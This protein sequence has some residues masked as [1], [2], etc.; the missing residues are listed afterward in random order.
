MKKF[1]TAKLSRNI[2]D[3]THAASQAP[4]AITQHNK[5]RFVMMSIEDFE[6]IRTQRAFLVEETPDEV[7]SWLLPAL[8]D[9]ARGGGLNEDS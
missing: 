9:V 4:I 1:S 5:P 6:R 2:G 3:V 8:D 7:A